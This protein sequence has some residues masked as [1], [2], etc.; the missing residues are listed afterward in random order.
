MSGYSEPDILREPEVNE[1][2]LPAPGRYTR[3]QEAD[4][5][6]TLKKRVATL[7]MKLE[8]YINENHAEKL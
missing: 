5:I 2:E 1:E 6:S 4:E 3:S 7:E 8:E